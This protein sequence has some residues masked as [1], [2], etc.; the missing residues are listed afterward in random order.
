MAHYET[1][2]HFWLI[3]TPN[4]IAWLMITQDDIL[5]LLMAQ[6]GY[7]WGKHISL[8]YKMAPDDTGWKYT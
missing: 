4:N 7:T 8:W 1:R 6:D 5:S 3:K 2:G